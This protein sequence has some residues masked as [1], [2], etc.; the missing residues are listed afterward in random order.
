MW[1]SRFGRRR[2]RRLALVAPRR[3]GSCE[4]AA[5]GATQGAGR[6]RGGTRGYAHVNPPCAC[7]GAPAPRVRG[8][9]WRAAAA[10]GAAHS[11]SPSCV[12]PKP[13]K[14]TLNGR[15]LGWGRNILK[16]VFDTQ[17][18]VHTCARASVHVSRAA[19]QRRRSGPAHDR[20]RRARG[21]GARPLRSRSAADLGENEKSERKARWA[22]DRVHRDT[23]GTRGMRARGALTEDLIRNVAFYSCGESARAR[24]TGWVREPPAAAGSV[25]GVNTFRVYL[26]ALFTFIVMRVW[27]LERFG[28]EGRPG[29]ASPRARA[30][31]TALWNPWWN[32]I[33]N[34]DIWN[35][36]LY[37]N[38]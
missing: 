20:K 21:C 7:A 12:C 29:G 28:G 16:E 31:C 26:H 18:A 10:T 15:F 6:R 38:N 25:F 1:R 19:E 33:E 11:S 27:S 4:C 3:R 2:P 5:A 13:Y 8:E 23:A 34:R 17:V 35:P 30:R 37:V 24:R 32:S 36:C 9:A 14:L 22:P